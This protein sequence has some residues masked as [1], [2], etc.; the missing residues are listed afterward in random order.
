MSVF[1]DFQRMWL[2]RFPN[3]SLSSEWEDDVK[4]SLN[5][6][7]LKIVE[8]TKELEQEMLYVEYLERLLSDVD[9]YKSEGGDATA[10]AKSAASPLAQMTTT[11]TINSSSS[12]VDRDEGKANTDAAGGGG[13]NASCV[14]TNDAINEVCTVFVTR[15][16][17]WSICVCDLWLV[18]VCAR[19]AGGI[20]LVVHYFVCGL[21]VAMSQ[22]VVYVHW[23]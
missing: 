19:G 2:T 16:T 11:T 8:L 12:H 6:H 22:Y 17:N 7:K 18:C 9:K 4:A 5:R 23:E 13:S 14:S 15:Q 3:N 10:F 20:F 21:Y 1:D